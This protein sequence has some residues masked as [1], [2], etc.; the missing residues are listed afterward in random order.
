MSDRSYNATLA[1]EKG[2]VSARL[3]YVWRSAF[4]ATNEAALFANPIGIWRQ[5][6]KSV[7]MQVSYKVND[8]M[9][10]DVGAINLT[11]EMQRQYYHFGNAGNEQLTN[12]GTVQVG[13]SVSVA[14]RWKM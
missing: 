6:E 1:Y 9:S 4:L 5:P 11:N 8:R 12:F 2:P 10:V 3:S 7:D 13:R 14:L